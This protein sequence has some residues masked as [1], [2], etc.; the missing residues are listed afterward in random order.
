MAG[1]SRVEWSGV[2]L[3]VFGVGTTALLVLTLL[4]GD[5]LS[6]I[7]VICFAVA[8]VVGGGVYGLWRLYRRRSAERARVLARRFRGAAIVSSIATPGFLARVRTVAEL[9]G[10]NTGSVVP[11]ASLSVVVGSDGLTVFTGHREPHAVISIPATAIGRVTRNSAFDLDG[12]PI[13]GIGFEIEHDGRRATLDVF[14]TPAIVPAAV[15]RMKQLL[16]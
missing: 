4:F 7:W 15:T 5:E 1:E 6:R 14:V 13:P 16:G 9:L 10:L 3:V 8:A 11:L 12:T 2:V